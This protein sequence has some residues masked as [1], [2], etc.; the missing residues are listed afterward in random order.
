MYTYGFLSLSLYIY[1]CV[2]IYVYI[3]MVS[4]CIYIEPSWRPGRCGRGPPRPPGS[5]AGPG[6]FACWFVYI[7][8][9]I[10]TYTCID[11]HIHIHIICTYYLSKGHFCACPD[12]ALQLDSF[13]TGSGQTR[14]SQKCISPEATFM[15]KCIKML[16]NTAQR[17]AKCCEVCAPQTTYCKM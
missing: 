9:Y 6:R 2:C 4:I 8:I 1:I 15:G 14:S 13:E 3:H 16:Q 5:R 7:Y 11:I 10:Y 17:V 12:V